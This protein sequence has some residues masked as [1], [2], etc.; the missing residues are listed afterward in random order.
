MRWRTV[1]AWLC[2]AVLVALIVFVPAVAQQ[3]ALAICDKGYCVMTETV[4]D[5]LIAL[6][7]KAGKGCT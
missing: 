6:A 3:P 5:Y 4:F 7:K 1:K 2:L